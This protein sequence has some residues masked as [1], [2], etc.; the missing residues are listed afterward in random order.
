MCVEHCPGSNEVGIRANPVCVDDVDTS[1]FDDVATDFGLQ[2]VRYTPFYSTV[3][4]CGRDLPQNQV[5][6]P[7]CCC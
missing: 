6:P 1:R 7:Q 5:C 4:L 3:I 2:A